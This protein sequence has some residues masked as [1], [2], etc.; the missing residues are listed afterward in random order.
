M[1]QASDPGT[2]WR[3]WHVIVVRR[4][5][6]SW[7][8]RHLRFSIP[9]SFAIFLL[10]I[11][12]NTYAGFYATEKASNS[13]TDI[14]LSNIPVFDVDYIFVYGAIALIAFIVILCLVHPKR[15]PFTLHA[16]SLFF[17]TRA[18]FVTLTHLG[19]YPD[20]TMLDVQSKIL[21]ALFGGGDEFFSGH[22]GAPFMMALVY[23]HDRAMRYI[24]LALSVFFGIVVLLGHLHYTI[25][26]LS[27]FFIT[28]SLYQAALY[29]FPKEREAFL[30]DEFVE[31][32]ARTA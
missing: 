4:Y 13:V 17:F 19:P 6:Q 21:L 16:L 25:D 3:D 18:I 10:S 30:R 27:A 15:T 14:I 22:T 28:Y 2:S 26:V 8:D 23:W 5:K 24:F 1:P 20:H 29:L 31:E 9:V 32:L 12:A 7:F 11:A